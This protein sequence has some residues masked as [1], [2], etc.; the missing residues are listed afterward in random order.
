MVHASLRGWRPGRL[1]SLVLGGLLVAGLCSILSLAEAAPPRG[2]AKGPAA[3]DG[4]AAKT[5]SPALRLTLANT[6]SDVVEM[7]RVINTKLEAG[8][9][10][11]KITPAHYID[12]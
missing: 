7:T 1:S 5:S 9:K 8:W 2:P 10:A 11:N 3:K 12:D 6:D 4:P